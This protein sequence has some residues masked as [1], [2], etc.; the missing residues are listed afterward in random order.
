[1]SCK[2]ARK[3]TSHYAKCAIYASF[4]SVFESLQKRFGNVYSN[5]F[6]FND[7]HSVGVILG[8]QF[9][10]RVKSDAAITLI[11]QNTSKDKTVLEII[12]CA[13]GTGMLEI[14]YGAHKA[15][16]SDVIKYLE[17]NNITITVDEEI[18][19]YSGTL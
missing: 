12:S 3:L 10:F 11:L 2:D 4:D 1:M 18:P 19:Y 14:S 5:R 15:Y 8:E 17:S 6:T 9:F 7:Y 16:V 13:G